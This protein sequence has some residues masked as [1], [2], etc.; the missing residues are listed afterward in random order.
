M[1]K[2][3]AIANEM[4]RRGIINNATPT[5]MKLQKLI[6]FAHG[7]HLALY[8]QPLVDEAFYAWPYGPVIPSVYHKFKAFGVL[9][10]NQFGLEYFISADEKV[11]SS[12]P[13]I[14]DLGIVLPLCDKIWE[15]FG[16]YS[17]N[18]LSE[19]THVENSPWKIVRDKYHGVRDILIPNDLIKDYFKGLMPQ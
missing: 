3:L 10:I 13:Q 18:Q 11:E 15:V 19:M 14:N 5:Q 17:G 2:S 16:G 1:E 9:G 6:Y 7:W 12:M 8:D 4:I